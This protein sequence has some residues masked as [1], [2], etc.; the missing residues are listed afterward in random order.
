MLLKLFSFF[1]NR[2]KLNLFLVLALFALLVPFCKN[3]K[4]DAS[5]ETLMLNHDKDLV[6]ARQMAKRYKTPEFLVVT[7]T[8]NAPLFS[9]KSLQNLQKLND[10]LL[11]LKRVDSTISILNVPLLQSPVKPIEELVKGLPTIK[12]KGVDLELAKKEFLTSPLYKDNLVS[13]DFKTTAIVL[14]LK[15]DKKYLELI[16]KRDS[17][18]NLKNLNKQNK[19]AIKQNQLQ[20]KAHRDKQREIEHKNIEDIR[21]ILKD[22]NSEAKVFLGGVNMIADDMIS[23]VKND[24]L[25]YGS[26][27]FILLTIALFAFFRNIRWVLI[28]LFICTLSIG[29]STGILGLFDFEITVISSNFI[30][31]QLII[32]LSIALHLIVGY[33]EY[34]KRFSKASQKKLV[35]ATILAKAKPSFLAVITTIAGFASLILSNIKPIMALGFMMSFGIGVSLIVS[36]VVFASLNSLLKRTKVVKKIGKNHTFIDVCADFVSRDKNAIIATSLLVLALGIYGASKLE[37]ENSFINYFKSSTEIY[38]SM[39][40]I[41]Q[42]LGGTTPLDIIVTFKDKPKEVDGVDGGDEFDDFEDEFSSK[43]SESKYW[44]TRPKVELISKIGNYLDSRKEIGNTQSFNTLLRIGKTLNGGEELNSFLIAVLYDKMPKEHRKNI[45]EPFVNIENNQLRFS[46]RIIDSNPDLKRDEF[47]KSLQKDL[48]SIV[49]KDMA[50]VRLS[51]FM[52]LYNNMLQSLY[53]SQIV[54]LGFVVALLMLMFWVIFRSFKLSLIAIVSNIVPMSLVFGLMGIIG[55]PLDMMSITIAAICVGIGVDDTIHYIHRFI[56]EYSH[57]KEYKKALKNAHKGIGHAM[58][59]TSF[60]IILGF[61]VLV[62]SNFIPIIY[63]ALLTIFVMALVLMG[64]L[65]LLPRLILF[66]KPL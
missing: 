39:K 41:D 2:P 33:E 20:L 25:L 16:E 7:Y 9:K 34:A 46:T 30:S 32:T 21:A 49:P 13:S 55:M 17:F 44:F 5:S 51:S 15:E 31:L 65:F 50:T 8:P 28:P 40:V 45:I 47:I 52:V 37:V 4:V 12:T 42:K 56:H 14:S 64:A 24:I 57:E 66:V 62:V 63:F 43:S 58:F 18:S 19:E 11:K 38:K 1:V 6:Y 60:A 10:R 27:L 53:R 22:F 29:I 23:F 59:Y 35:F 36:F 54:T 26:S 3:L 61:S 48:D